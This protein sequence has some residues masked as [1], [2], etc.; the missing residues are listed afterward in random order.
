MREHVEKMISEY[1]RMLKKRA[2]LKTQIESYQPVT[3]ADVI[4][5]MTFSQPEGERVQTS[6]ITDKTCTI[7]LF[8]RDKVNQLNEEVIG[9][10]MKEYDHLDTEIRFLE[11]SI[12]SLPGDLYDVMSILVLDG[13]SWDE[14]EYWLRMSRNSIATRRREAIGM[15]TRDYQRRASLIEAVML[16]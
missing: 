8:F 12:R 14:A 15:I 5:S 13:A 10:W 9:E 11:D 2:L 4:D 7:A 3:V 16:S 1:P 6:N